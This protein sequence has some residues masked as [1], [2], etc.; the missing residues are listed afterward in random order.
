MENKFIKIGSVVGILLIGLSF[1]YYLVIFLPQ[2][3]KNRQ[4]QLLKEE[5]QKAQEAAK[6]AE[7]ANTKSYLLDDCLRVAGNHYS[8]NL[9]SNCLNKPTYNADGSIK[10]TIN[11]DVI[12]NMQNIYQQEQ[13][14][15]YNKYK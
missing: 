7:E 8:Q 12:K 1:F 11:P 5:A 6:A 13:N 14:T 2:K 9:E 15:C 3:E 4:D 10:C